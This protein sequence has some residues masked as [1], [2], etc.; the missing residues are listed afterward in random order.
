MSVKLCVC[1]YIIIVIF[2]KLNLLRTIQYT[3]IHLFSIYNLL[4]I[5]LNGFF[6]IG[7]LHGL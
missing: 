5:G 6:S 4:R 2:S 7:F 3:S 1:H